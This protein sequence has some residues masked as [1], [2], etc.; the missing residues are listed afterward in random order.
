MLSLTLFYL[1][2][3]QPQEEVQNALVTK[4]SVKVDVSVGFSATKS[5][6][7]KELEILKVFIIII[8]IIMFHIL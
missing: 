8:I 5:E 1:F 4:H 2:L 6:I 3:L 7:R